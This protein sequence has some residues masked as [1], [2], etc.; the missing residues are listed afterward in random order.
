MTRQNFYDFAIMMKEN[1]NILFNA[2]KNHTSIYL[3]GY[4]LEGYIKIILLYKD[5]SEYIGHLGDRDFLNKFR[6]II[7]LHPEFADNILQES[8]ENYPRKLFNGGGNNT[9]KASWKIQHR[10][11]VEN[12]TDRNFAH[13]IQQEIENI[14]NALTQ[15]RI[16]GVIL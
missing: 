6:R 16:D 8:N 15:L 13:N 10:Y 7:S 2:N 4:V 12:W 9:T 1:S 14:N 3:A 5:E 11:K